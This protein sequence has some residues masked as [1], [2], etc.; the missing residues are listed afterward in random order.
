MLTG[1]EKPQP[2]VLPPPI[3]EVL[4]LVPTAVPLGSTLI[5]QL[6][7]PQNVEVRARVEAVV[8]ETKF[9]EG[10]EVKQGDVLFELDKKSSSE[11][12]AAANGSLAE[13]KAALGKSQR[14][15]ERLTPLAERRAIP[16]QDL[17]NAR[18]AFEVAEASVSTAQAN[19]ETAQITLGYCEVKAPI[20][21][22]IGSRQVSVGEL[23]GKGE[24][25]LLATISTL[26]PIWFYSN[27]SEVD[28][29]VGQEKSRRLG[30]D[31]ATL[32][33]TLSLSNGAE[34][35]SPGSFVFIDRAVDAKTG[36]LRVRA[37][38][39]NPGKLLRPG[40]FARTRVD[41]GTR[42]DCIQIPE[43]ALVSL[44]G[45]SFIWVIGPDQTAHQRPITI[46]E[47]VGSTYLV[48]EGVKPGECIVVEGLQ[49]VREGLVVKPLNAEQIAA[50]KAAALAKAA[51]N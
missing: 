28:F 6:E 10:V 26:D 5:G 48:L 25:T 43:R 41:L 49:K 9:I 31:F 24:S 2:L 23:V 47:Q 16:Q 44:Q 7:S 11:K 3:V 35:S 40:M 13:A 51:K 29:M 27:V 4:E 37:E 30:R 38:F 50:M 20:T 17:D 8:V 46:G 32:P 22:L 14:D 33:L 18:A 15:I 34:H 36:T 19:V 1:C 45:K 21:G 39:P 12:L 42:P